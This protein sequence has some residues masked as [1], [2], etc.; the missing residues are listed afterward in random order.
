MRDA[1]LIRRVQEG[2]PGAFDELYFAYVDRVHRHV[3]SIVGADAELEDLV[4]QSF[5]QVFRHIGGY[6]GDASFST[7]LHRIVVNTALTHL[8]KRKRREQRHEDSAVV[9]LESLAAD[10]VAPEEQ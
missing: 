2:R 10:L 4:Q 6:R 1:E 3:F 9:A 8:R 7:W 5:V